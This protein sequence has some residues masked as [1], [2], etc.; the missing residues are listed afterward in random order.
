MSSIYVVQSPSGVESTAETSMALE[1]FCAAKGRKKTVTDG[2]TNMLHIFKDA[3]IS[4]LK[5]LQ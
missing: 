5:G 2:V 1:E 3:L 4:W